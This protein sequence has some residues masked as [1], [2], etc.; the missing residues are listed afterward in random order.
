MAPRDLQL[1]EP[2]TVD[3]DLQLPYTIDEHQLRNPYQAS[4]LR[5]DVNRA[6]PSYIP[7]IQEESTLAI[8]DAFGSFKATGNPS[9]TFLVVFSLS[10]TLYL[11]I[12]FEVPVFDTMIHLIARISN[13]VVFG[14]DLCR[15][16]AFLRAIVR[17]AETVPMMAP[18]I[19]WTP[20]Y[21]RP[22]VLSLIIMALELI[23]VA[24]SHISYSPASSVGRK[25]P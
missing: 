4:V 10:L 15:D 9:S 16:E 23:V 12:G 24:V 8:G 3:D 11:D 17:F 19:K 14:V 7:E 21:L 6:L 20:Q 1:N 25:Q 18:F 22:C 13:R 5:T 2:M